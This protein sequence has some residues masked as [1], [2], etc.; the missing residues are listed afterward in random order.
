MKI[1]KRQLIVSLIS[2]LIVLGSLAFMLCDFLIP[3]NVWTH[4]VLNF[5][6]C[7]FLG[8]GIMTMVIGFIKSSPWY[9]FLSSMLFGLT[10][11]Y[12]LLQ[13]LPWWIGV[14]I[15]VVVWVICAIVSFMSNGSQTENVAL[16]NSPEYKTY[17]ERKAEE[18]N[19]KT[20]EKEEL[21]EIKSFKD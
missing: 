2:I 10:L 20:E 17:E 3:L 4:P 1:S 16:N 11:I 9:F 13:Y 8:F 19:A 18:E 7:L 5:F 14:V 21:P 6:F 12:A 15:V